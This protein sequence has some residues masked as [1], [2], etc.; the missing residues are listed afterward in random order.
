MASQCAVLAFRLTSG[1]SDV[2]AYLSNRLQF[3][4]KIAEDENKP[5]NLNWTP[6]ETT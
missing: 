2:T 1:T 3:S 5:G 6:F 4:H